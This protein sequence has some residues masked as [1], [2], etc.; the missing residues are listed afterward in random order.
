MLKGV[1]FKKGVTVFLFIDTIHY[2]PKVWPDPDVF[3]PDRFV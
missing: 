1:P 3:N 2:D